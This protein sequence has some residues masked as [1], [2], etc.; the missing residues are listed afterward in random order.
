MDCTMG[1]NANGLRHHVLLHYGRDC[2]RHRTIDL[3]QLLC[4]DIVQERLDPGAVL[5]KM[6]INHLLSDGPHHGCHSGS[7]EG[8]QVRGPEGQPHLRRHQLLGP[9][10]KLCQHLAGLLVQTDPLADRIHVSKGLVVQ[11]QLILHL[12]EPLHPGRVGGGDVEP[13]VVLQLQLGG[14]LRQG[15][16]AGGV[17]TQR[18][19][20][21]LEGLDGLIILGGLHEELCQAM[22]GDVQFRLNFGLNHTAEGL[23]LG[24]LGP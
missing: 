1:V 13:A 23:E 16:G 15:Q 17:L 22:H 19:D 14:L 8:E 6:V 4:A 7:L 24:G 9:P 21:V 18:H 2:H 5:F 10:V 20:L 3:G 12:Y 11:L